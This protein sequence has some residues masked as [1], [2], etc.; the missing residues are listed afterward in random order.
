MLRLNLLLS[1][2]PALV[3]TS[4]PPIAPPGADEGEGDVDEGDEED[5]EISVEGM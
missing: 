1:S 2:S 5:D 4:P 3:D